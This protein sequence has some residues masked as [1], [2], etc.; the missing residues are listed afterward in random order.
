MSG[1]K[2]KYYLF[3]E[4]YISGNEVVADS[5]GKKD[6]RNLLVQASQLCPS[7]H[8]ISSSNL[9][10]PALLHECLKRKQ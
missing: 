6:E 1:D 7:E 3:E 2:I 10:I 5:T 4:S 9:R 8:S